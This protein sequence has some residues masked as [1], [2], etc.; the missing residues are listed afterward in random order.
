MASST[1][2]CHSTP[3]WHMQ[4]YQTQS[5]AY[6]SLHHYSSSLSWIEW[7]IRRFSVETRR[8]RSSHGFLVIWSIMLTNKYFP[9]NISLLCIWCS[10]K[11]SCLFY[12]IIC[13]KLENTEHNCTRRWNRLL[14][15]A[16]CFSNQKTLGQ[17]IFQ[18]L[19]VSRQMQY[20]ILVS[21]DIS[22]RC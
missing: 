18:G 16:N 9:P 5:C 22:S 3:L 20:M 1:Q 2:R 8:W 7:W 17:G 15:G 10:V 21:E 19:Y 13:G 12:Y 11:T 4:R 6:S 14:E